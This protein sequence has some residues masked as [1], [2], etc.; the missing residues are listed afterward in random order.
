MQ[1]IAIIRT[2]CGKVSTTLPEK[3]GLS[4]DQRAEKLIGIQKQTLICLEKGCDQSPAARLAHR[5]ISHW[6]KQFG[7]FILGL[8][9]LFRS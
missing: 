6:K 5:C 7:S 8:S 1:G 3:M 9:H 2:G 4:E